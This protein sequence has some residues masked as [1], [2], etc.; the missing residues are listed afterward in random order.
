[1]ARKGFEIKAGV[2]LTKLPLVEL[3][4]WVQTVERADR[5]SPWWQQVS[6]YV[7]YLSEDKKKTPKT[8]KK[9]IVGQPFEF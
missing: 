9:A 1:M 7:G 4:K 2:D 8:P 5:L 6:A 3:R